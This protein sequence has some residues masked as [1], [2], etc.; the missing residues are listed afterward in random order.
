VTKRRR[1]Q[2][3]RAANYALFVLG[4]GLLALFAANGTLLSIVR[5]HDN[6]P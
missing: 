4:V 6:Q 5:R 1:Q 3:V 2:L